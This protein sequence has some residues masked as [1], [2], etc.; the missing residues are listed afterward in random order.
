MN[1]SYV[2]SDFDYI[3]IELPDH[4]NFEVS[5]NS[6]SRGQQY[7][8]FL[9]TRNKQIQAELTLLEEEEKYAKEKAKF[10]N[11]EIENEQTN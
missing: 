1:I 4:S 11:K 5:V 10:A 2:F 7:K 6:L 3:R 8:E 9:E